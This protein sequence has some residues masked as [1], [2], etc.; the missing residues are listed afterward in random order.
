MFIGII[1]TWALAV[2]AVAWHYPLGCVIL[3]PTF[4]IL[5]DTSLPFL[6]VPVSALALPEC[7]WDEING[8]ANKYITDDYSFLINSTLVNGPVAPMCPEMIDFVNCKDVGPTGDIQT[9]L[10]WMYRWFGTGF[11][12]FIIGISGTT[13][14]R[15]IPRL[16]EYMREVLNSFKTASPSVMAQQEWCAY[17]T[18]PTL[19]FVVVLAIP[20]ITFLIYLLPVLIQIGTAAWLVFMASPI[21]AYL[22]GE[23]HET[24]Y[25][26]VPDEDQA[27]EPVGA[28]MFRN[29]VQ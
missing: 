3:W 10:Y 11:C 25:D 19:A 28:F 4:P 23:G 12:E 29:F 5:V 8:I 27:I 9:I 2:A 13:I 22:F 14:G 18:L 17:L 20:V 1:F 24:D 7:L 21:A 6:G 15:I 16:D 26:T